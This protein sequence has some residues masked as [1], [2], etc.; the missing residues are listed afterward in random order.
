M[1]LQ[2]EGQWE[3]K[4]QNQ[5]KLK[6]KTEEKHTLLSGDKKAR[7]SEQEKQG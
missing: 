2:S 5:V 7:K 3:I 6:F 1:A 4:K